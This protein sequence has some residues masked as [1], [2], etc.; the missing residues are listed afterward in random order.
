MENN[1]ILGPIYVLLADKSLLLDFIPLGTPLNHLG[2]DATVTGMLCLGYGFYPMMFTDGTVAH[3]HMYYCPQ[4]S[5]TLI[6][7]QHI[8][9]QNTNSFA[10][11][12]IQSHDM[13]NAYVCSYQS[14]DFSSFSDARLTRKNNLFYFTQLSLHPQANWLSPLLNTELWHQR[15]GHPGMHQLC[16]LQKC[17]TGIPSGL[18]QQ[19]HP[20]HHCK[21][22][23][24]AQAR[25]NPMGP[26]FSL[27][28][29]LPGTCFHLDFGFMRASSQSYIKITG[30]TRVVNSY[31][32]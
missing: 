20:L 29:L 7:P 13:D 6:S 5:E 3:I 16:H 9:T 32:G 18:H 22:C 30:A 24:D 12:D 17:T 27:E 23:S 8:C 21:I 10:G 11:F 14:P 15:L 1:V 4:L 31:D 25:K 28:H 26:T 2:A 19:V